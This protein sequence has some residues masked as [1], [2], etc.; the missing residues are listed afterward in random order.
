M[1]F[2]LI[3]F[4]YSGSSWYKCFLSKNYQSN[5]YIENKLLYQMINYHNQTITARKH[6]SFVRKNSCLTTKKIKSRNKSLKAISICVGVVLNFI[7]FWMPHCVHDVMEMTSTQHSEH[8]EWVREGYAVEQ[9]HI[10]YPYKGRLLL[11]NMGVLKSVQELKIG[12]ACDRL[13]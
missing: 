8:G 13:W 5:A 11:I 9:L 7:V 6:H 1:A 12:T 10:P 2:F 3:Y 4:I